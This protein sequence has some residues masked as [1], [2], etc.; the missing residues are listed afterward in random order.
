MIKAR[1][2]ASSNRVN[3]MRRDKTNLKTSNLA[4]RT[5]CK[6]IRDNL[7]KIMRNSTQRRISRQNRTKISLINNPKKNL[8]RRPS[9]RLAMIQMMFQGGKITET[10]SDSRLKTNSNSSLSSR[11]NNLAS[12][13][14]I[15]LSIF[16]ATTS[17]PK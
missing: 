1:K 12:P 4:L 14:D 11:K 3:L 13:K 15:D 9:N 2:M 16:N 6:T 17:N 8:S 10:P 7:M 5:K